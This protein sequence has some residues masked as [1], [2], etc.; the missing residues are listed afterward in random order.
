MTKKW[1]PLL[2]LILLLASPLIANEA[3]I[4]MEQHLATKAQDALDGVYGDGLF[5]VRVSTKL[6][7]AKYEV[8]YTKQSNPKVKKKKGDETINIL[9]GYPVIK[10]LSPENFNT[11]PFDSVTNYI[12]PRVRSLSVDII[13]NKAIPRSTGARAETLVREV[14]GLKKSDKVNLSFKKFLTDKERP[15]VNKPSFFEEL[16][17]PG[18][19][20]ALIAVIIFLIVAIIYIMVH[21]KLAKQ[22]L[23]AGG[24]GQAPNVSV[25]PNLELPKGADG[26]G[27]GG[28]ISISDQPKI[29][30]YFDFITSE[31]LPSLI[32]LLKKENVA[33]EHVSLIVSY[34]NP[35]LASELL[36][37]Y[38]IKDQAQMATNVLDEKL[39]NRA[40]VEKLETKIRNWLEC[41]VG[42]ESRFKRIFDNI[43]SEIKKKIMTTLAKTNP[44]AFKKFRSHVLI[45][46]DLKLLEDTE[47]QIVLSDAN[48]ELLSQALVSVDEQTYKKIDDNLS[49][50]AKGMIKQYLDL[51]GQTLSKHHI[52]RAQDYVL[53][54]VDKLEIEGKVNLRSKI[55]G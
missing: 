4:K 33:I 2:T 55:K 47:L 30:Q 3:Q 38:D 40:F 43:S 31:N 39:I 6:Y 8:K 53:K 42:G 44:Q 45:F 21:I 7:P 32:H 34:M 19:V 18:N 46:D 28:D 35:G 12:P 51:K 14:L 27:S 24:G 5:I 15:I 11:L 48:V 41:F 10:N 1:L 37:A 25:N 49:K 23:G 16:M 9:P 36:Q 13:V 17:R 22:A 29:K 54:I 20:L 50:E 26:G 52:E